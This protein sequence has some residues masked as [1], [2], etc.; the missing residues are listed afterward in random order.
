L[1]QL[2]LEAPPIRI[3]AQLGWHGAI[4]GGD[5][6]VYRYDGVADDLHG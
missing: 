4:S 5:L 6:A 3:V 1:V 2:R